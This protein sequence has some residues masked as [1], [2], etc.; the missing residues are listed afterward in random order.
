M[1]SFIYF[2]VLAFVLLHSAVFCFSERLAILP[3]AQGQIKKAYDLYVSASGDCYLVFAREA[4]KPF[5]GASYKWKVVLGKWDRKGREL[6]EKPIGDYYGMDNRFSLFSDR[7]QEIFIR[8]VIENRFILWKLSSGGKLLWKI[9]RESAFSL[10]DRI[11]VGDGEGGAF[12]A[13]PAGLFPSAEK[14]DISPMEIVHYSAEGKQ[15]D[16]FPLSFGKSPE[17]SWLPSGPETMDTLVGIVPISSQQ[18][19]CYGYTAGFGPF[20]ANI[21]Q[22]MDYGWLSSP[23][24]VSHVHVFARQYDRRGKL[25]WNVLLPGNWNNL[26]VSA[27]STSGNL[28]LCGVSES[29]SCP[30]GS[31]RAPNDLYSLQTFVFRYSARGELLWCRQFGVGVSLAP[32]AIST[33]KDGR[34][35]V[36]G[37][38]K[39]VYP[40]Q[41]TGSEKPG[42]VFLACLGDKGELLWIEQFGAMTSTPFPS[43][44]RDERGAVYFGLRTPRFNTL[45]PLDDVQLVR[46]VP[47]S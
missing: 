11:A 47:G 4:I 16:H 8:G 14:K 27:F 28:T 1:K 43:L 44:T 36:I 2:F 35:Y 30:D 21:G 29:F 24:I 26:V 34:S 17:N 31:F 12:V 39:E 7:P 10:P 41:L 18:F 19:F 33:A 42:R 46:F 40:Q 22:T 23:L 13:V 5:A 38:I 25:L 32:V 3:L 15:I 45:G 9:E 6:W 20:A 37:E